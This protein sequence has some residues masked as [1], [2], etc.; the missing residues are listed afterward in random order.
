MK[1]LLI[2]L[3][4]PLS[5]L[6]NAGSHALTTARSEVCIAVAGVALNVVVGRDKSS[7]TWPETLEAFSE[8]E[9]GTYREILLDAAKG[10]YDGSPSVSLRALWNFSYSRCMDKMISAGY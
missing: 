7:M 6:A 1:K 4:L 9:A 5:A 2:S 3:I 10:A 8:V